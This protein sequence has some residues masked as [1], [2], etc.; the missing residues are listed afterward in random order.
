MITWPLLIIWSFL[1]L[2]IAV[3][4]I[5]LFCYFAKFFTIYLFGRFK[6]GIIFSIFWLRGFFYLLFWIFVWW[7][8][9][10][11]I[12]LGTI[13]LWGLSISFDLIF[14]YCSAI[15]LLR[16]LLLLNRRNTFLNLL[17]RDRTIQLFLVSHQIL[18]YRSLFLLF[19]W[20]LHTVCVW[21]SVAGGNWVDL[22]LDWELR[23]TVMG[24][25]L[26]W[27]TWSTCL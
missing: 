17:L 13:L 26:V 9:W 22:L 27:W 19:P 6:L 3:R 20:Q 1:L 4:I 24:G 23:L 15:H 21:F 12:L 25:L 7:R 14:H 18:P 10:F 16:L 8:L 5:L 2:L 11:Y